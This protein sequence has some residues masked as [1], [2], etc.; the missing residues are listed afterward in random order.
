MVAEHA[1]HGYIAAFVFA[2]NKFM[3]ARGMKFNARLEYLWRFELSPGLTW[4]LQ[5]VRITQGRTRWIW[6]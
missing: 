3:N 5:W 1:D 6:V 4:Q 2:R